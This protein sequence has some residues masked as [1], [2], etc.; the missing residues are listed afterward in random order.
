MSAFADRGLLARAGTALVLANA[1]FWPTVA[2][3]VS[4]QLNRWEQRAQHITNPD[5]RGLALEK[6]AHERFNSEVAATLATLAPPHRRRTVVKA[7]VAYELMYDYLDGLTELPSEDPLT[8]G[9]ALY[10]SFIAAVQAKGSYSPPG[11]YDDGGYLAEMVLA[12]QQAL[13]QLPASSA[14]TRAA[15]RAA[16]RCAEAQLRAHAASSL[17]TGQLEGWAKQEAAGSDLGWRQFL[18]GSASSVLSVHALIAAAANDHTTSVDAEELDT[19]YLSTCALSTMLDSLIDYAEDAAA[20]HTGYLSY[21]QSHEQLAGD[22]AASAR[23]AVEHSTAI[24]NGAHHVM[25]LVGVAAYYISDPA[26]NSE[27]A[28][29][30]TRSVQAELEPLMAPTL[31]VMRTWRAA[32]AIRARLPR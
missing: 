6:L 4:C 26:A 23:H 14:I 13:A 28:L 1:R 31:G 8:R 24:P 32:K 18:A 16:L 15:T 2:P 29:P 3:M 21:Y 5:L 25:T 12:V 11:Q 17:G 22:L 9:R 19:V 7:I 20:G 10:G 27:L 30:I